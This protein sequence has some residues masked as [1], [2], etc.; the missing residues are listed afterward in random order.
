MRELVGS[1]LP[2]FTQEEIAK[3]N[4]SLDFIGVNIITGFY[5]YDADFYEI[6]SRLCYFLDWHVNVTGMGLGL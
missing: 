4:G 5:V 6:D 3:V 2:V 1:R